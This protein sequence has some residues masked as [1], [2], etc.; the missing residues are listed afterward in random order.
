MASFSAHLDNFMPFNQLKLNIP[1]YGNISIEFSW[2]IRGKVWPQFY[3]EWEETWKLLS[4]KQRCGT[5]M[6]IQNKTFSIKIKV[7]GNWVASPTIFLIW[8]VFVAGMQSP[9]CLRTFIRNTQDSVRRE[10]TNWTLQYIDRVTKRDICVYFCS[11]ICT[12][13]LCY[14]HEAL[15]MTGGDVIYGK[16]L[17]S[18]I[19]TLNYH[20][21]N[22][23]HY[24]FLY[25]D[26]NNT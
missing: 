13:S 18:E 19:K 1:I 11:L 7:P 17:V 22:D 12:G 4:E 3:P 25:T 20:T 24:V 16:P 6:L 21:K 26:E 14:Y 2:Y 8:T 23:Y 15:C 10:R 9:E 5:N